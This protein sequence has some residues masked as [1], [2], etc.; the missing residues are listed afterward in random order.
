ML[1]P[2]K[3][4]NIKQTEKSTMLIR[5]LKDQYSDKTMSQ[6]WRD[7]P[8]KTGGHVLQDQRFPCR[9]TA[10]ASA[11]VGKPEL[12]LMNCCRLNMYNSES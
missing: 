4:Q 10:G 5:S 3:Q 8:A 7:R 2:N 6:D 12:L 1:L 11:G 9:T